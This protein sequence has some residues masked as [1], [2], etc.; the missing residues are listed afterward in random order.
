MIEEDVTNE[1]YGTSMSASTSPLIA[2]GYHW[3]G[4][5]A[6]LDLTNTVGRAAASESAE[7]QCQWSVSAGLLCFSADSE[8]VAGRSYQKVPAGPPRLDF[9]AKRRHLNLYAVRLLSQFKP[10]E[11]SSLRRALWSLLQ[12][13]LHRSR[14][15]AAPVL[16]RDPFTHLLRTYY[17]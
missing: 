4:G 16:Q 7:K 15:I 9:D 17:P 13:N 2:C 14:I 10:T 8:A 12:H 3:R 11:G 5:V 1:C 6:L